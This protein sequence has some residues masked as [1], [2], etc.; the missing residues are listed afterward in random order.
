MKKRLI[1]TADEGYVLTNGEIYGTQIYLE[2]AIMEY[3]FHEISE[4]EYKRILEHQERESQQN[5]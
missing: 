3:T 2:D 1:L 5:I 4:A